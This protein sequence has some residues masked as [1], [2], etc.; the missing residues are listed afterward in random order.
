VQQGVELG[1]VTGGERGVQP[2]G[3]IGRRSLHGGRIYSLI[4]SA[5]R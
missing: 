5:T 4:N 1:A 2:A 3:E